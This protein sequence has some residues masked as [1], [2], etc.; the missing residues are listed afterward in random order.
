MLLRQ[1][2]KTQIKRGKATKVAYTTELIGS[3][4]D[5]VLH[6]V[7]FRLDDHKTTFKSTEQPRISENDSVSVAGQSNGREFQAYAY[8]NLTNGSSGDESAE[9]GP[10]VMFWCGILSIAVGALSLLF[11]RD[12]GILVLVASVAFVCP[13]LGMIYKAVQVSRV[14]KLL[15]YER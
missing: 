1:Y 7:N 14:L 5:I 6:V 15:K 11:L 2:M 12:G 8:K 13:G 10:N 4:N 9:E 3:E